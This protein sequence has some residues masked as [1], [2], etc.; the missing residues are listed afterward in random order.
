MEQNEAAA[1][2]VS[3]VICSQILLPACCAKHKCRYFAPM[4]TLT[5]LERRD[6]PFAKPQGLFVDG[7]TLWISSLATRCVYS[8]D[9][10]TLRILSETP[11]PEGLI[12]WGLTKVG[13]EVYAV[14]GGEGGPD[15]IRTVR[16]LRPGQGF[17]P[18]YKVLCPEESGSH[19][20]FDGQAL[21]LSQWYPRKIIALDGVGRAGRVLQV[22]HGICGHCFAQGAFWALTTDE[23]KEGDYWLTRVDPVTGESRDL[24]RIGFPCRALAFD[25]GSFLTNHRA[26]GQLVRL[27]AP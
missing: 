25:G 10:S 7:E 5:E 20:S 13:D 14:V 27:E 1:A 9:K 4:H 21:N 22:P 19:L 18:S 17:D 26:A 15:D 2:E 6:T 23:E 24:A 16:R 8:L 3:T 12:A 11:V